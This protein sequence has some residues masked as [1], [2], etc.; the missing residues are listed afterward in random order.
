MNESLNHSLKIICS[1]HWIIKKRITA[2]CW[3]FC[4]GLWNCFCQRSKNVSH[5]TLTSCLLNCF[6]KSNSLACLLVTPRHTWLWL[7]L[8]AFSKIPQKQRLHCT[9][10]VFSLHIYRI[11]L[12]PTVSY[13]KHEHSK[14][15]FYQH[16]QNLTEKPVVHKMPCALWFKAHTLS[17]S[18][19]NVIQMSTFGL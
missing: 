2:V 8:P 17:K 7:C 6:C 18:P 19:V 4:P 13:L 15:L 3:R 9:Y 1:K 16:D 14:P 12:A 10:L 11:K 5:W